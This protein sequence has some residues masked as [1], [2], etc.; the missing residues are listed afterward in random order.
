MVN[1]L[2]QN[3]RNPNHPFLF[4]LTYPINYGIIQVNFLSLIKAMMET[5]TTDIVLPATPGSCEPGQDSRQKISPEPQVEPYPTRQPV[6][7]NTFLF[8]SFNPS[9]YGL[10]V[11]ITSKCA[12]LAT[13]YPG[14]G[15]RWSNAQPQAISAAPGWVSATKREPGWYRGSPR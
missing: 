15:Y 2:L 8:S 7:G 4:T 10:P 11:R 5:S 14:R 6:L 3:L 12:G 1:I 13:R 9:M